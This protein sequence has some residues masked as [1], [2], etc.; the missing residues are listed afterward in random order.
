[1]YD[2]R[3]RLSSVHQESLGKTSFYDERAIRRAAMQ[4]SVVTFTTLTGASAA[5][6]AI[7]SLQGQEKMNVKSLQEQHA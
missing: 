5:A 2:R 4:Y 6:S 1:M 3:P 7:E